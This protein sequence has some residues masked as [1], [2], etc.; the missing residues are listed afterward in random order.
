MR[1]IPT[2]E[3]SICSSLNLPAWIPDEHQPLLI[4][5]ECV[6]RQADPDLVRSLR[7]ALS[8]L[9]IGSRLPES[10]ENSFYAAACALLF[11]AISKY[12]LES[13]VSSRLIFEQLR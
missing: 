4:A 6:H 1:E 11:Q 5:D 7:S 13:T 9:A 2:L 8:R 12:W 10:F 3:F